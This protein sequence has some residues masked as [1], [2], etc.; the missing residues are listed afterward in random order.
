MQ[1]TQRST[2]VAPASLAFTK[3]V[4]VRPSA[5][6]TRPVQQQKQ[7][8]L[9]QRAVQVAAGEPL[10][11]LIAA[12]S[13][14][15]AIDAR[16]ARR[17]RGGQPGRRPGAAARG[18]ALRL[19]PLKPWSFPFPACSRGRP[20]CQWRLHL[21][22]LLRGQAHG[23]CERTAGRRRRGLMRGLTLGIDCPAESVCSV[24]RVGLLVSQAPA[25]TNPYLL[26]PDRCLC[27]LRWRPGG[28]SRPEPGAHTFG[29]QLGGPASS[30]RRQP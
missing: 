9:K 5:R 11:R 26:C 29:S 4:A 23:H 30:T 2:G 17:E 22:H 21:L 27:P 1:A 13:S 3:A 24:A 15:R 12:R 14:H 20:C 7:A 25:H 10:G 28:E 19:A 6:A 16:S 18:A 8:A